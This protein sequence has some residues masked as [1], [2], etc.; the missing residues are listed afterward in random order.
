MDID[1]GWREAPSKFS[2][3]ILED[4]EKDT[5]WTRLQYDD[6]ASADICK[7]QFAKA[8]TRVFQQDYFFTI[9]LAQEVPRHTHILVLF[10]EHRK[11]V[12]LTKTRSLHEI[13]TLI[14]Q[15]MSKEK[16]LPQ[17]VVVLGDTLYKVSGVTGRLYLQ[18]AECVEYV[19]GRHPT[20]WHQTLLLASTNGHFKMTGLFPI[21]SQHRLE[22]FVHPDCCT[23]Y[24]PKSCVVWSLD[25][26]APS[27]PLDHEAMP[28]AVVADRAQRDM[29]PDHEVAKYQRRPRQPGTVATAITHDS[30]SE[31][32]GTPR[33]VPDASTASEDYDSVTLVITEL[34]TPRPF[35]PTQAAATVLSSGFFDLDPE[36]P[37][38]RTPSDF[39][40][41]R[42]T[43]D[44][45]PAA[46]ISAAANALNHPLLGLY[47]APKDSTAF[48]RPRGSGGK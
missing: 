2:P 31:T 3:Q 40:P 41:A 44:T 36:S 7:V 26:Q 12:N 24:V 37:A 1:L 39:R 33:L 47:S 23:F 27:P 13:N 42:K 5:M 22:S 15:Y 25:T 28:A 19:S 8:H 30:E 21:F 43:N 4:I 16:T 29:I 9:T 45:E 6:S 38:P 10:P 48:R 35:Q 11:V 20:R 18:W 46:T 14:D 34:P 32:D 17:M